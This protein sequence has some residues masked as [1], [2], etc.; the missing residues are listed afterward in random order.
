MAKNNLSSNQVL[1]PVDV[2]EKEG[3]IYVVHFIMDR[4]RFTEP[5]FIDSLAKVFDNVKKEVNPPGGKEPLVRPLNYNESDSYVVLLP[6]EEFLLNNKELTL[7]KKLGFI[8]HMSR[9]G[10]TLAAQMLADNNRFYVL[11]EPHI[12][13]AVLD[14]VLN[15]SA[16][17]RIQLFKTCISMLVTTA[18]DETESVFIKFRS[19]NT[20]YLNFITKNF[21]DIKWLYIHRHGLEVLSSVLDKPP[22]WLRS[23]DGYAKYFAT[24]LYVNEEDIN[25][26]TE[27][28]FI[29]RILGEFCK[30]VVNRDSK[31]GLCID[32][33]NLKQDF[34]KLITTHWDINLTE[35]EVQRM[36]E[37]SGIYSKNTDKKVVF[38]SDTEL[39]R[40][41]ATEQQ[42][43]FIDRFVESE[44]AKL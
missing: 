32:Y 2:L 7:N 41:K 37:V 6:I 1:M 21:S 18:P 10:S 28:E 13:N 16:L 9:C 30:I 8:F 14:P 43:K 38:T 5:F 19:W 39:K 15:I 22:G 27:D 12:I 40:S 26:M 4:K 36:R 17:D 29:S 44:R 35:S 31:Q 34:I 23:R 20:F 3:R 24:F 25:K 33:I 11:S 42:I